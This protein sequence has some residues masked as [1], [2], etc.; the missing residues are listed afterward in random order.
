MLL[1][2]FR[3]IKISPKIKTHPKSNIQKGIQL[4]R[5]EKKY[6]CIHKLELKFETVIF[7]NK[8][9]VSEETL[10]QFKYGIRSSSYD[11]ER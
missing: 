10:K 1:E 9:F 6:F 5:E 7:I 2:Q 11:I 3:V 4:K 8:I